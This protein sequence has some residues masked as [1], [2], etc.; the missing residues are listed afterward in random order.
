MLF[1]RDLQSTLAPIVARYPQTQICLLSSLCPPYI[2]LTS[3]ACTYPLLT[4][5]AGEENKTIETVERIWDFL[6]KHHITD[7]KSVV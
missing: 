2:L 1:A 5:P 4:I 6:L 7:R 3:T